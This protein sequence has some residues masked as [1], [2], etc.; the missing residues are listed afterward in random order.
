MATV[1][2]KSMGVFL[3]HSKAST[4]TKLWVYDAVVRAKL[5]YGLESVQIN[6]AMQKR[7]VAFQLRGI[8]QILKIPTT[9]INRYYTNEQVFI[10][11]NVEAETRFNG[12]KTIRPVTE[13]I[14]EKACKLLGHA[15]RAAPDDPIRETTFTDWRH[16]PK[17]TKVR[18]VG[19]PRKLWLESTM[20]RAWDMVRGQQGKEP[21]RMKIHKK[22][23]TKKLGEAAWQYKI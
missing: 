21:K 20:Q 18:R 4:K 17:I 3:K 15:L 6:Q 9:F 22:R 10:Q 23:H 14:A 8:R 13:Y 11:A 2:W 19:R 12:P 1:A 16:T 5:V 7:L